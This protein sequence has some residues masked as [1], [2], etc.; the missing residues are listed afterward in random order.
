VEIAELR[1]WIMELEATVAELTATIGEKTND[2]L[3]VMDIL[4]TVRT[5]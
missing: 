2:R 1:R 5:L 4:N 3:S